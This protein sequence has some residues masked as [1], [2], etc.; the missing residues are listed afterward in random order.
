M[1]SSPVLTERHSAP[2]QTYIHATAIIIGS[3]GVL[4]RG[5]S[6][7][8][9]SSLALALLAETAGAGCFARLIGDDRIGLTRQGKSLILRGHPAISGKI[10]Q[11][12]EGILDVAWAPFAV[13][14]LV[15][16]LPAP[17]AEAVFGST[18]TQIEGVTLP[19]VTLPFAQGPSDR[20]RRVLELMRKLEAGA[21]R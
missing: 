20:A 21:D 10:E 17:G 8:G 14:T 1:T 7:A 12:G 2:K 13:A 6:R 18:L 3:S 9:K 11:R 16:D 4:I 19:L 5:A 15:I